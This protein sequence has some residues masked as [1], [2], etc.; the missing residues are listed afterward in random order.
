MARIKL[1]EK[2]EV[3]EE[4]KDVYEEIETVRGPGKVTCIFKA[5]ANYPEILRQNW[6]KMKTLSSTGNFSKDFKEGIS[7]LV[8]A[9]AGCEA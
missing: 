6:N 9:K 7:V 3:R 5:W 1:P 8:S 4:A 2:N